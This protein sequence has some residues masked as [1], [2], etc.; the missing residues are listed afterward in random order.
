MQQVI[1]ISTALAA[2]GFE[3][4]H[5]TKT[6]G[7][8]QC[9]SCAKDFLNKTDFRDIMNVW[10]KVNSNPEPEQAKENDC[11]NIQSWSQ[12]TIDKTINW[13]NGKFDRN[14]KSQQGRWKL[15][16]FVQGI[17]CA[18]D[19][20]TVNLTNAKKIRDGMI[21]KLSQG[22]K[23]I[24]QNKPLDAGHGSTSVA[25]GK[26]AGKVGD[27]GKYASSQN[28][29]TGN[30]LAT[31]KVTDQKFTVTRQASKAPKDR[32]IH[33]DRSAALKK[34][35][36]DRSAKVTKKV[37]GRKVRADK[38]AAAQHNGF[39]SARNPGA[40]RTVFV[41]PSEIAGGASS[42]KIHDHGHKLH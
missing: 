41:R 35:A 17:V 26:V 33:G 14:K 27:R 32:N 24:D 21:Q 34:Q 23:T 15:K 39:A 5:A 7:Q 2:I 18:A 11:D 10:R 28:L 6:K 37:T 12:E 29:A 36:A 20:N 9:G 13:A 3:S 16:V 22:W 38:V 42:S 8:G 1:K 40:N 31:V 25:K 19:L 4:A 30:N